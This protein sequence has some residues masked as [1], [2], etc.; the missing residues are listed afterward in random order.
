[1]KYR[2]INGLKDGLFVF[3]GV[4]L[5]VIFLNYTGF[6]FGHNRIWSGLGNLELINI[7]EDKELNGLLVLSVVLGAIAFSIGFY[8]NSNDKKSKDFTR[9]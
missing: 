9:E 4:V 1:M 2:L 7:F 6:N 5:V 3:I 8:S